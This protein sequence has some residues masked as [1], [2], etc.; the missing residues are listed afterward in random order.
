MGQ[1]DLSGYWLEILF[2]L[3]SGLIFWV[4]HHLSGEIKKYKKMLDEQQNEVLENLINTKLT[5]IEENLKSINEEIRNIKQQNVRYY[6]ALLRSDCQSYLNKG[7]L[8]QKEF[9]KTSELIHIY[10]GLGGN[11]TIHD[12]WHRVND[13]PLKD[14]KNYDE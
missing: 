12:L 6:A 2:S 9:N 3:I 4:I 5:P 10:E 7:Y 1:W 14:G 8:S 11:G 13:L